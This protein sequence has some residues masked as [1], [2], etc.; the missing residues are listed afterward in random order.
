MHR[1]TSGKVAVSIPDVV[2]GIFH[3]LN[4]SGRTRSLRSTRPLSEISTRGISS[5]IKAAGAWG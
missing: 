1:A 4:P 3:L 5:G 2:F